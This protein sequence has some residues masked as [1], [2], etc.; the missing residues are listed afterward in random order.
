MRIPLAGIAV[1][2]GLSLSACA[3]DYGY[4][5]VSLGVGSGYYG[6][7]YG[8]DYGYPGYGYGYQP[9]WGWNDSF[10]YPGSGYYVYDRYRRPFR[11]TDAQRRYWLERRQQ[12][13]QT[14]RDRVIVREN[15]SGFR[16]DRAGVRTQRIERSRPVRVERSSVPSSSGKA[17]VRQQSTRSDRGRGSP[18]RRGWQAKDD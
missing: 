13:V 14:S 6:S 3:T 15:W 16:R 11:W 2:A 12:A 7:N 5:G 10:Y 8:Y 9:Y 17:I 18:V 4:S 1:A